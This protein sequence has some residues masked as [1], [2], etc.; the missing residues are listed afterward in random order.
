M[1]LPAL[2]VLALRQVRQLGF[3]FWNSVSEV[4]M[5]EAWPGKAASCPSKASKKRRRRQ[6]RSSNKEAPLQNQN[7]IKNNMTQDECSIMQELRKIMILIVIFLITEGVLHC[8]LGCKWAGKGVEDEADLWQIQMLW[9]S[10]T[11]ND[12]KTTWS[13]KTNTTFSWAYASHSPQPQWG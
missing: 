13:L 11:V 3:R 9:Q 12:K 4:L 10:Q 8:T 5:W 2:A 6:S 1:V 7:N